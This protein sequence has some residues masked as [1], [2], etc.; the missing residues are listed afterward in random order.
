MKYLS[1]N[2]EKVFKKAIS[3]LEGKNYVKIDNT[4]GTFIPLTIEHLFTSQTSLFLH[5]LSRP[6]QRRH[7]PRLRLK[8]NNRSPAR[9][10]A[11]GAV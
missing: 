1:S 11:P 7:V 6:L 5:A 4:N 10:A 9:F 2:A 8:D 3:Y